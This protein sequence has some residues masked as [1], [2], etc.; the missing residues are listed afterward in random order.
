ME[1][2]TGGGR[3]LRQANAGDGAHSIMSNGNRNKTQSIRN[4][5]SEYQINHEDQQG[6]IGQVDS[7]FEWQQVILH[8]ELAHS[9]SQGR[10][11]TACCHSASRRL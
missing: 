7:R 1:R 6:P 5:W 9:T 8:S 11:R 3:T 4:D 10:D 2:E